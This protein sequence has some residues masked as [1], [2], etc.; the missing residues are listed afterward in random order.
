[1]HYLLHING[2]SPYSTNFIK[3]YSTIGPAKSMATKRR[4]D[5]TRYYSDRECDWVARI[6]LI[7]TDSMIES[8]EPLVAWYGDANG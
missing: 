1:M 5:A 3:V 4:N 8:V 7:D 6:W 2:T